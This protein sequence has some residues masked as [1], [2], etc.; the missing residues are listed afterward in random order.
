MI[1]LD[2]IESPTM[3][4]PYYTSASYQSLALEQNKITSPTPNPN[5]MASNE[6]IAKMKKER[7]DR[8]AHSKMLP[9]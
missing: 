3:N 4:E 2:K 6:V 1:S 9:A 5:Q 7:E 8:Y